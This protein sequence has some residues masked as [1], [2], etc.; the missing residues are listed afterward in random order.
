MANHESTRW[1]PSWATSFAT[2]D[3]MEGPIF[4]VRLAQMMLLYTP[5]VSIY[6]RI[7]EAL[8]DEHTLNPSQQ[9]TTLKITG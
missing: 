2:S 8:R 7:P 9:Q 4:L 1:A 3:S 6:T 5:N